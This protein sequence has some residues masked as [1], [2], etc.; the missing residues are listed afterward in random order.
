MKEACCRDIE[1][2]LVDL[3]DN[4]LPAEHAATVADHLASCASC[5][6]TLD[7]LEKSIELGG[8]IWREDEAE[9]AHVEVSGTVGPRRRRRL[10]TGLVVASLL[11]M[12]SVM[13]LWQLF[14]GPDRPVAQGDIEPTLEEIRM[15][16]KLESVS[17]RLLAA[18]D[19]LAEFPGGEA[20]A[21]ERYR[22]IADEYADTEA[23][24][25][26]RARLQSLIQRRTVQ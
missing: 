25:H 23:S 15:V 12:F 4:E 17:A 19:M 2:L 18:A 26:V 7:A 3:A 22:Y 14:S 10:R 9:L 24:S 5:R 1:P 20:M 21:E 8:A 13:T 6:D 16:I 11:L